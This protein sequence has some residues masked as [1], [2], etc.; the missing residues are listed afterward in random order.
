MEKQKRVLRQYTQESVDL[1]VSD[2]KNRLLTVTAASKKYKIP[3]QSLLR[4]CTQPERKRIGRDPILSMDIELELVD[5][6]IYLDKI[7]DGLTKDELMEKAAELSTLT[8]AG[9]NFKSETPSLGF[10]HGF[11]KR[12]PNV[13]FRKQSYLSKASAVVSEK[14]LRAYYRK[15]YEYL[16][17]NDL[18]Y[19]LDF[20]ERWLNGDETNFQLN[21]VPPRVLS[22]KGKKVVYRVEKAKPKESVTGM[23]TFSADGFMYKPLYILND[24]V[25]NMPEIANACIDVGAKFGFAQTGKI[26]SKPYPTYFLTLFSTDNGWQT[27][28]SF[29]NY[30]KYQLYPELK[31]RNIQFPVVY[32]VDGHASHCSFD[33]FKW[34]RD[35]QIIFILSYPNSTHITQPCDTSIFGPLKRAWPIEVKKYERETGGSITLVDFVK[36]LKRVHDKVMKPEAVIN[37]FRMC[38]IFPLNADNVHYDRCIAVAAESTTVSPII[39]EASNHATVIA[40]G[41]DAAHVDIINTPDIDNIFTTSRSDWDYALQQPFLVDNSMPIQY[42]EIENDVMNH[43]VSADLTENND[44]LNKE[45]RSTSLINTIKDNLKNLHTIMSDERPDL[46]SPVMVIEQ[47]CDF[48]LSN[49]SNASNSAVHPSLADS[50][51]P[52]SVQNLSSSDSVTSNIAHPSSSANVLKNSSGKKTITP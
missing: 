51:A 30:I 40:S 33:L 34:C 49:V 7:G 16:E 35:N 48:L 3:R 38:G 13:S 15:I 11:L 20:P 4:H 36:I 1:A 44:V 9:K 17:A 42:A 27:K 22:K 43:S 32:F 10:L 5:W 46:L 29:A 19:L 21:A 28:D 2:V 24:K 23:Y 31:E 41:S 25:A 37:G 12:H 39:E 47:L 14:D 52:N 26:H 6:V 50:V 8:V 18:L 45:N